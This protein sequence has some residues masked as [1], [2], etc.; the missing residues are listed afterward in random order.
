MTKETPG[1]TFEIQHRAPDNTL[2]VCYIKGRH[3]D[4]NDEWGQEAA[5]ILKL[6]ESDRLSVDY[7]IPRKHLHSFAS[8][9]ARRFDLENGPDHALWFHQLLQKRSI[10]VYKDGATT[11]LTMGFLRDIMLDMRKSH[12]AYTGA[13]RITTPEGSMKI[14]MFIPFEEP[15][16]LKAGSVPFG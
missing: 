10:R 9:E 1:S 13:A 3:P 2:E 16:A 6:R 11:G 7:V 12:F 4:P 15:K 5:G 14:G 8:G